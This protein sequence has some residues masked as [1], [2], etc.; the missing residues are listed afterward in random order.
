VLFLDGEKVGAVVSEDYGP[1]GNEFTG[2]VNWVQI[3]LVIWDAI[4]SLAGCGFS[5]RL[6]GQA[7]AGRQSGVG[8]P[9]ASHHGSGR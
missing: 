7:G 9:R 4:V 8:G 5:C 6:R 1:R 2:E 3:D